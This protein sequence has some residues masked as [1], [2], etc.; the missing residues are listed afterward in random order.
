MKYVYVLEYRKNIP[1]KETY[2]LE[3]IYISVYYS[4]NK[5]AFLSDM[6]R[7]IFSYGKLI[8]FSLLFTVHKLVQF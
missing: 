6:R 4:R 3:D 2:T 8:E 1:S 7:R 5:Y